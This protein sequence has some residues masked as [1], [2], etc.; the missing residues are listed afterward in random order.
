MLTMSIPVPALIVR[1]AVGLVN[2]TDS[3]AVESIVIS[4]SL[5]VPSVSAIV[6]SPPLKVKMRLLAPRLSVIGSRPV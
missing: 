3:P 5:A 4:P 1:L 2:V 6:S